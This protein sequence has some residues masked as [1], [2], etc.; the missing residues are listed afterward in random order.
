MPCHY[1]L[2][3]ACALYLHS[4]FVFHV[5]GKL[6][7]ERVTLLNDMM[8][9][10]K[11]WYIV[12]SAEQGSE[13]VIGRALVTAATKYL[14]SDH[15]DVHTTNDD[16][17]T[18]AN[19]TTPSNFQSIPGRGLQC[20]IDGFTHVLIGNQDWLESQKIVIPAS[21]SKSSKSTNDSHHTKVYVAVNN[22]A[23]GIISLS[24]QLKPESI[25]V[26]KQLKHMGIDVW[27]ISGDRHDT[28]VAM[29]QLC[30]I[31]SDH[32]MGNDHVMPCMCSGVLS[33]C[34]CVARYRWCFTW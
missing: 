16:T 6:T 18:G 7:V 4:Y 15:T 26:V 19:F 20:T 8:T 11:L 33:V 1:S 22:E 27:M 12:A 9:E 30:G 10:E 3:R 5:I 25:D 28:A 21:K 32:I 29:G 31:D 23:V 14:S 34:V 2:E 24:D 17:C 13:H